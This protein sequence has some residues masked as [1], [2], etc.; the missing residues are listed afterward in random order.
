[1]NESSFHVVID[2]VRDV[3]SGI[4]EFTFRR[5]DGQ[6]FPLYSAGSHV[7]VSVP[8]GE[9]PRR[10]PYS[11]LGDPNERMS[12]RIAVRR[13]EP[14]RGGSAWLHEQARVGDRLDIT[15]PMNLFPLISTARS[16]LLVAGGIG[17]TPILSQARELARRGA[18]FE[19]HYAWR[20]PAHAAYVAELEALAPGKVHHYDESQGV[21]IDFK[22]LFAG[23][24]LG[25]HFYICGPT[26]MVS[27]AMEGGA[28]MGW[29]ATN[30]H[31][32][33]FASAEPG[34]PF[35]V[36]LARSGQRITVPAD[37]SLL[38][39]LEQCGAPVNALCRGGACGQCE[40]PVL[41]ADGELLHHD[42]YL[43]D[44]DKQAGKLVMPCVSRFKGACLTLDL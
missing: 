22:T 23:R 4:R 17:V 36:L 26:P 2:A 1:M 35:D 16:H 33:R 40:T 7:V 13:Q 10:N 30:L 11:L 21:R 37:L 43:R 24:R 5:A 27:A 18:D 3:A 12:W 6:P 39:A 9:R 44:A 42:V 25:T 28:A 14:S 32:E 15:A 31:S 34:E 41:S 8:A 20:S 19:V 29:P 38:E